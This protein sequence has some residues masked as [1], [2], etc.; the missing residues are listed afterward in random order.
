MPQQQ[1]TFD[2]VNLFPHEQIGLHSAPSWELSYIITGRG[3]RIIGDSQEPFSEG[4]VILIPPHIPHCWTFDSEATDSLGHISNISIS[5][6]D[7]FLDSCASFPS[8][9]PHID[10]LR[11]L[12]S[13]IS[14]D[15]ATS[16]RII[17]ILSR[18]VDESI[19][20]RL[21]SLISLIIIIADS[22]N[23]LI[24]GRPISDDCDNHRIAQVKAFVSCN[25]ARPIS[26]DTISRHVGMNRAS[27]C[28][29]FKRHTGI[30]FISYLNTIR[31]NRA[32][33]LLEM[34][35]TSISDVA[36]S[37]GF[38]SLSYFIRVFKLIK[39]TSPHRYKTTLVTR[40]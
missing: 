18:M 7:S 6:L 23:N 24:V 1:F 20:Q 13:A 15:S 22:S 35:D 37:S 8:L 5:F 39:G 25:Y 30:T 40:K 19:P 27:F 38:N 34:G 12:S 32:C 14:F 9:T 26:I 10:R 29:F 21:T 36:Y 3:T 4:E 17:A 2:Y 33:H 11:S 28:S 31:I 16:L